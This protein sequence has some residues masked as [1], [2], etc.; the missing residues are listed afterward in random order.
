[1]NRSRLRLVFW[2]GVVPLPILVSLLLQGC[3]RAWLDNKFPALLAYLVA[4][5]AV[6]LTV[7]DL[8]A[9]ML[10]SVAGLVQLGPSSVCLVWWAADGLLVVTGVHFEPGTIVL[11]NLIAALGCGVAW[12]LGH[13]GGR[14][15]QNA[16]SIREVRAD[17][18]RDATDR[19][20]EIEQIACLH[21]G[22]APDCRQTI[23]GLCNRLNALPA[24]RFEEVGDARALGELLEGLYDLLSNKEAGEVAIAAKVKQVERLTGPRFG[25]NNNALRADANA[26]TKQGA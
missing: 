14:Q 25:A 2:F 6:G 4:S 5:A 3:D 11:G 22:L 12:A 8:S 7:S 24:S 9:K 17:V 10:E 16:E 15:V 26:E 13:L 18:K 19:C 20:R 21:S 1:V 23:R